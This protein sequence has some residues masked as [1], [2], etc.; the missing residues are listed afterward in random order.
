MRETQKTIELGGYQWRI[1]KLTPL[2]GA[3]LL[4][5]VIKGRGGNPEEFLS[6]LSDQDYI[7]L[8]KTL[9]SRVFQIKKVKDKEAQIPVFTG[10]MMT[11][12]MDSADT[13]FVLTTISLIF[14][15]QSFFEGNALKELDTILASINA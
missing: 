3:N 8:Q 10:D 7:S 6:T 1:H 12:E 4:R 2:E 13:I 9:L 15:L 11:V 5:K 14:N